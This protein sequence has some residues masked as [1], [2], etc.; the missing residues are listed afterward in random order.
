[1]NTLQ[2]EHETILAKRI[3]AGLLAQ[4]LLDHPTDTVSATA[5][6]AELK[7]LVEEGRAAKEELVIAHLGLA[8]VVAADAARLRRGNFPDLFQECCLGLQQAV[9]SYDWRKGAFGPYAGMWI[10]ASVKRQRPPG[11][12]SLDGL[13]V[14]DRSASRRQ[15]D[16]VNQAGLA[17]VLELIPDRQ[18]R[19]L[20]LRCGWEGP[21][22]TLK[23]VASE[24]GTTIAKVRLL[25]RQGIASMRAHWLMTEAA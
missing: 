1:M 10:R 20:K 19:V 11:W 23:G 21:S 15:E 17:R 22:R 14:E 16:C 24:L 25:E 4:D 7:T 12:V 2:R 3:E 8:R 13:E 6:P 5:S 9:M 18:R